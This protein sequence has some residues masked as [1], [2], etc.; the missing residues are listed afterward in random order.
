MNN[1]I[2]KELEKERA[3]LESE[4]IELGKEIKICRNSEARKGLQDLKKEIQLDLDDVKNQINKL[5]EKQLTK[6]K[7][8]EDGIEKP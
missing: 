3:E 4:F 1:D 8:N 5:K 2:L 7:T 6:E